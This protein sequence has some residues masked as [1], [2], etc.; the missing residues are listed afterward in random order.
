[1][2]F[3]GKVILLSNSVTKIGVASWETRTVIKKLRKCNSTTLI[4]SISLSDLILTR[5]GMRNHMGQE[6]DSASLKCRKAG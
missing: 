2:Y 5:K 3:Q 1:M 6:M 4:Y